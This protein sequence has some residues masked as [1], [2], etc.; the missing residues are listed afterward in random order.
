MTV[1]EFFLC[2]VSRR[3]Q[4]TVSP[5]VRPLC[6]LLMFVDT[7]HQVDT[8]KHLVYFFYLGNLSGYKGVICISDDSG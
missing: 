2:Q 7:S 5:S 8:L 6:P 1:F 3:G 4:P